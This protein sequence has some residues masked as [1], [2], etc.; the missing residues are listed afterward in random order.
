[1]C[2]CG[3]SDTVACPHTQLQLL[4]HA[5][6]SIALLGQCAP[7]E[8]GPGDH[9]DPRLLHAGV[10]FPS[11]RSAPALAQPPLPPPHAPVPDG[12]LCV[13]VAEV[14]LSVRRIVCAGGILS[15]TYLG[16]Y[17][18]ILWLSCVYV[19]GSTLLAVTSIPGLTGEPPSLWGVV[20][21]LVLI[22]VGTGGI[23][24]QHDE[25]N[26]QTNRPIECASDRQRDR[27]RGRARTCVYVCMCVC[28]YVCV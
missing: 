19:A 18:T 27:D 8:P 24:V 4:R 9:M 20:V 1:M 21:S 12:R 23:K 3:C 14:E 28:M 16:K 25:R 10:L 26:R 7:H 5:R 17:R 22:A 6:G 11:V 13:R 15:D 2:L